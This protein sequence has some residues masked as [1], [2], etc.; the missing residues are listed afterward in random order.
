MELEILY[1]NIEQC[2]RETFHDI[3]ESLHTYEIASICEILTDVETFCGKPVLISQSGWEYKVAQMF[4][5]SNQEEI[6]NSIKEIFNALEMQD[7][8]DI[9]NDIYW[10]WRDGANWNLH[11]SKHND[12]LNMIER[13]IEFETVETQ[14]KLL[15]LFDKFEKRLGGDI[16]E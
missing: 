8:I 11:F 5:F 14:V 15:Q 10:L 7:P 1:S 3:K 12:F 9:T 4:D 6:A 13:Q 16:N 2:C